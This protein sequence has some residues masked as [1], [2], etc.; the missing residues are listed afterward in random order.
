[1]TLCYILGGEVTNDIMKLNQESLT[2]TMVGRMKKKR[3]W[4]Q[5]SVIDL[6]E[7]LMSHCSKEGMTL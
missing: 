6:S 4:H 1:M 7:E 2:W 3:G 5:G